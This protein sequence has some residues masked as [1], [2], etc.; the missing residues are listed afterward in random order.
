MDKSEQLAEMVIQAVEYYFEKKVQPILAN[1][2]QV[3]HDLELMGS[4]YVQQSSLHELE[5]KLQELEQRPVVKSVDPADVAAEVSR[6]IALVPPPEDGKSV[7]LGAIFTEIGSAVSRAVEQIPKPR[8][9]TDGKDGKDGTNGKDGGRGPAGAD[10]VGVTVADVQPLL[11]MMVDQIPRPSDGKDGESVSEEQVQ[12]MVE[13]AFS[14]MPT[15][16]DGKDAVLDLEEIR[17]FLKAE[18]DAWPRPKDGEDGLGLEDLSVELL[19]G[20]NLVLAF[21]NGLREKKFELVIPWQIYKGLYESG[22]KYQA[23]DVVT[24]AGSQFTAKV[25]TDQPPKTGDWLLSVKRG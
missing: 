20:R 12:Q 6:Q 17:R 25:D 21:A 5:S 1:I 23:G 14:Q 8:D 13:R 11:Q 7:D 3:K 22:R 16:K 19:N 10:G 15:P 24:F 9:G 18:V 2:A 4:S